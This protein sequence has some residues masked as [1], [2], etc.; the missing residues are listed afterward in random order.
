ML[1]L[2]LKNL[3]VSIQVTSPLHNELRYAALRVGTGCSWQHLMAG[4]GAALSPQKSSVQST[5]R[6]PLF[7]AVH[8]FMTTYEDVYTPGAVRRWSSAR[9]AAWSG[10]AAK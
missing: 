6:R 5:I 10:R 1:A 4:A 7:A 3:L 8:H 9:R 2:L